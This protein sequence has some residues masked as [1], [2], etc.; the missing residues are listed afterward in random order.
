MIGWQLWISLLIFSVVYETTF[1]HGTGV[2]APVTA[3]GD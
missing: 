3:G 1:G 2:A